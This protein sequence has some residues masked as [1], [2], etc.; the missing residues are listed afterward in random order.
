MSSPNI[1]AKEAESHSGAR[2][3]LGVGNHIRKILALEVHKV[4][5]PGFAESVY[6]ACCRAEP[7]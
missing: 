5:G 6:E 1:A 2:S 4:L 3:A 7:S